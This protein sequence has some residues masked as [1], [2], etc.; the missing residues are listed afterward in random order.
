MKL[1]LGQFGYNL[2]TT[3]PKVEKTDMA[4]ADPKSNVAVLGASAKEDRYSNKAVKM[5][6][7]YGHNPIP[8]HP[9]GQEV[10]GRQTV[11]SL[12]DIADKVDTLSMY[13]SPAISSKAYESIKLLAPRRVVFNPG[14]ENEELSAKLSADGIEVLNACTLVMLRTELF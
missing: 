1:F 10:H 7:E 9:S 14:S 2:R 6:A 12:G 3:N 4:K 8:V 5:L 13:I 11:K